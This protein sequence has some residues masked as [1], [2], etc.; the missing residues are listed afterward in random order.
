MFEILATPCKATTEKI[1]PKAMTITTIGSTRN[2]D[3][4]SVYNFNIVFDEP[5]APAERVDVGF[6]LATAVCLS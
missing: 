2:P 4:S 6:S 1:K 5:P 3:A